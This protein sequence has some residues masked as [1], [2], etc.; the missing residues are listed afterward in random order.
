MLIALAV[1][2]YYVYQY[3]LGAE[4]KAP[5]SCRAALNAC[6]ANCRKTTTEAADNQACQQRCRDQATACEAR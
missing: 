1:M 5:P 6:I 2:G 3:F 4:S